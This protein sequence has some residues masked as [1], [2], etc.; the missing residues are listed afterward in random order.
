MV[1]SKLAGSSVPLCVGLSTGLLACPHNMVAGFAQ[2]KGSKRARKKLLCPLWPSLRSY[3]LSLPQYPLVTCVGQPHSRVGGDYT[4]H[5]YQKPRIFQC[6][7][8]DWLPQQLPCNMNH[9][10]NH[11]S[12][13]LSLSNYYVQ[14]TVLKTLHISLNP[15]SNPKMQ[16]LLLPPFYR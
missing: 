3:P 14:G 15:D 11:T 10:H 4:K 16:V 12:I 13:Y 7:L 8:G 2:S 1:H 9:S 5:G 6:H